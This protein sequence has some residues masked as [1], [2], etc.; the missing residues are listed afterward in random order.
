MTATEQ[1]MKKSGRL[2]MTATEQTVN[3]AELLRGTLVDQ[4]NDAF[5]QSHPWLTSGSTYSAADSGRR[6]DISRP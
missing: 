5:S 6:S 3:R 4:L 2:F 1:I